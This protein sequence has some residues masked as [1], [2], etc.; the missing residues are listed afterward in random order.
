MVDALSPWQ[1]RMWSV[2]D[3]I[4]ECVTCCCVLVLTWTSPALRRRLDLTGRC[5]APLRRAE[6]PVLL[7]LAG[8]DLGLTQSTMVYSKHREDG[9]D[10]ADG[11]GVD[12]ENACGGRRTCHA[13]GPSD[14]ETYRIEGHRPPHIQGNEDSFTFRSLL[15]TLPRQWQIRYGG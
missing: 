9:V 6:I 12:M 5:W 1:A 3:S 14:G 13:A 8:A 11:D 10:G 15:L 2:Q 4:R 7:H